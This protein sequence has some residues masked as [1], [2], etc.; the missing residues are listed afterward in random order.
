[1]HQW[2][3]VDIW[4][5]LVA[6]NFINFKESYISYGV[7]LP[8]S[9]QRS[10]H[11]WL[12]VKVDDSPREA[13]KDWSKLWSWSSVLRKLMEVQNLGK[14]RMFSAIWRV[15]LPNIYIYIFY[16]TYLCTCIYFFNVYIC[17]HLFMFLYLYIQVHFRWRSVSWPFFFLSSEF[18]LGEVRPSWDNL[19]CQWFLSSPLMVE[20]PN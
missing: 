20:I 1:M 12:N 9:Y 17:I 4:Y 14:R 13:P 5:S 2:T 16:I 6:T 10:I 11:F 19:R 18:Q 8:T 15:T 7:L 3:V